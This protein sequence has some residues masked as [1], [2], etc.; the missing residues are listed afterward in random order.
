MNKLEVLDGQGWVIL[1]DSYGTDLSIVNAARQ[2]FAK[3]SDTMGDA[4]A[5]LIN[6][7]MKNRH[8]TPFEMVDFRFN[9]KAPIFVTREWQRH[10]IASYNEMSGRYTEMKEEFYIPPLAAMRKQ[11]GKPGAY[12]FET[13]MFK[14]A[15]EGRSYIADAYEDAWIRYKTLLEKGVAKELA[16]LVLPVGIMT[17]FTYKTNLRSLFNFLSLRN[18]SNA[19]AEIR[20]YAATM[21]ELIKP[22]I[23][24]T[25]EAFEKN[26][27]VSP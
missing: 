15:F 3:T 27:R 18:A 13:M 8:G 19:M 9:I 25:M 12:V 11:V 22:I 17:Q 21:E 14:D 24:V 2:S 26:G 5:G 1:E 6:F 10:R 23:P 7:L 16:R 20:E 4:E